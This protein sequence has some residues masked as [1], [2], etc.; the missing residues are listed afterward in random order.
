M[1]LATQP[2]HPSAGSYVLKLRRDAQPRLGQLSGRLEHIASGD[3]IDFGNSDEM[4]AWLLWHAAQ[5]L[6]LAT[7]PE[8][9]V[10]R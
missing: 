6:P 4:L 1:T 5:A 10:P 7:E 8:S 9:Q 2:L 3:C